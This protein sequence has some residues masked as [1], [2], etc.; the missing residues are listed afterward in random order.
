[1]PYLRR[2][3]RV[4]PD[5]EDT[6]VA[7]L[8]QAGTL[9]VESDAGAPFGGETAAQARPATA[10]SA[11]AGRSGDEAR[12]R[13][14]GWVRLTAYFALPAAGLPSPTLALVASGVAVCELEAELED[15]DWMAEYRRR[16][17]PFLLG[18]S[19]IVDPGE[20]EE[21][22][23]A[24]PAAPL[25]E[26]GAG[27]ASGRRLLRLPARTAFGT[28]SHESTSLA[29]D[30]L[31]AEDLAG[32][33]VLDVG[34]GTGILA[35][36]ALAWGAAGAVAFDVDPVAVFQARLNSRLNGLFPLLFTGRAAALRAAL[37]GRRFDVAVVNV[38][39]EQALPDLADMV[40]AVA[41]SG[42]LILSGLL[43]E[44]APEVLAHCAALGLG[45]TARRQ[46]GDWVALR[47]ARGHHTR[48]SPHRQQELPGQAPPGGAPAHS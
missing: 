2:V 33:T 28:G 48:P 44:R 11:A 37:Q 29:I 13:A 15:R 7:D 22:A 36:A 43:A 8:W 17:Q 39:P 26:A 25:G 45:E 19:L 3:Y 16:S 40:P 32:R 46:A 30:L 23:A 9:G 34:T 47:L 21:G 42:A 27:D 10:D 12:E 4:H 35:F 38:V 24:A 1:M 6:L 41:S 18:R 14:A 31:E 5:H 20:P